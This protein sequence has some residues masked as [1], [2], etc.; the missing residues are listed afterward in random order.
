MAELTWDSEWVHKDRSK[1]D[2]ELCG[3]RSGASLGGEMSFSPEILQGP[4]CLLTYWCEGILVLLGE[5]QGPN[6]CL[7]PKSW[8]TTQLR[9]RPFHF[10]KADDSLEREQRRVGKRLCPKASG[11][12]PDPLGV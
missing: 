5:S 11:S 3:P 7:V 8:R 4:C 12:F 10:N 1:G 6:C 2:T 9:G